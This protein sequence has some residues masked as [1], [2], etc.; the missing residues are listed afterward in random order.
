MAASRYS[1]D[2]ASQTSIVSL[3]QLSR[4]SHLPRPNVG[5]G[6]GH[7][8]KAALRERPIP[9]EEFAV[10]IAPIRARVM[11]DRVHPD[12]CVEWGP[13]RHDATGSTCRAE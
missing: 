7:G 2:G 13:S 12:R 9:R 11:H 10:Y 4:V 5:T 3:Q 6:V 8:G 1:R